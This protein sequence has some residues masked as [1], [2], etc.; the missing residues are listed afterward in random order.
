MANWCTVIFKRC[1]LRR[2]SDL[3]GKNGLYRSSIFYCLISMV[4]SIFVFS[5]IIND[6]KYHQNHKTM[7]EQKGLDILGIKP[8]GEAINTSVTKSFEG[9]EGFLKRVCAPALEEIGLLL[10]DQVR[11]WRLNNI[12]R[13]LQKAE[14]KMEFKDE[15][16]QIKA[17]PRVALSIIDNGSL[18]D[19]D[20]VQELWAGLFVSSCTKDGQNDENLIFVDLLKQLTVVEA[21]ILKYTCQRARKVLHSNG[22]LTADDYKITCDELFDLTGI[23]DIHRL[24][25]ELDH[26]R[27]L[28]L[29]GHGLGGG[30]FSSTDES[31]TADISPSALA[32]NL[33]IKSQGFNDEPLKFWK[34]GVVTYQE[35]EAE[36]QQKQKEETERQKAEREQRRQERLAKQGKEKK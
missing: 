9:V 11:Q 33:Y 34:T 5:A 1:I 28:Q 3:S 35:L 20:E 18:N 25:R 30:G 19:D 23:N 24:D 13:I 26:L 7:S 2:H 15:Q 14:G 10:K 16:L 17:H 32:L 36:N 29:I 21:K 8:I 27:S 6:S 22:L 12:L 4:V 31:L